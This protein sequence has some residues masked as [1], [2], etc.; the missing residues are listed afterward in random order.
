MNWTSVASSADGS[1]LL[2]GYNGGTLTTAGYLYGSV[3]NG[4]NWTQLLGATNA[5]WI[6][7]ASSADGSKLAAAAYNG[8]IYTSGQ[9]VSTSGTNGYLVGAYQ[10][11]LELQYVGNGIFLPLSHE[12][13]IR[14]H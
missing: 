12:G 6:A 1:H 13:T 11:A 14:A 10:S 9:N 7:L 2:A 3:N 8:Y 5:P 4:L